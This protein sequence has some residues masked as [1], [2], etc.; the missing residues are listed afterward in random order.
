MG[1]LEAIS[2]WKWNAEDGRELSKEGREKRDK[3]ELI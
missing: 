3:G 2:N 1:R